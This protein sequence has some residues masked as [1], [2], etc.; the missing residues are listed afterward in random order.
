[1]QAR[2]GSFQNPQRPLKIATEDFDGAQNLVLVDL[3]DPNN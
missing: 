3:V 1:M 2:V